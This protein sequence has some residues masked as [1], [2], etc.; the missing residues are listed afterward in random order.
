MITFMRLRRLPAL[1]SRSATPCL[2]VLLAA[3]GLY[4]GEADAQEL[5]PRAYWPA[6]KGTNLLVTAYQHSFGDVVT[7]ATLPLEGVDSTINF[8]QVTWQHTTSIFGRSANFQAN[9]PYAWGTTKGLVEGVFRQR[10][11]SNFADAR[12]L[13]SINLRGA[14]SMNLAE[15]R[16]LTA[17]PRTIVGASLLVQAPTGSY[18]K[19]RFINAGTNRWAAKLGFGVIWPL[20]R[21]WLLETHFGGWFFGDNDEFIGRKREQDPIASA[22]MHLIRRTDAE[23]WVALD[24]NYYV[25]G[26]TTVDGVRRDDR[27]RNSRAGVT[28]VVPFRRRHAI[29]ASF[30]TGIRT[31]SG[32]DFETLSLAYAYFW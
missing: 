21:K 20:Q 9:L 18:E 2:L 6:P 14:P 8:A 10:D 19:D 17:N 15:F 4:A 13:L 30:S 25:G 11:I 27:V 7:D 22:E 12:L 5:V 28:M 29:R 26:R 16:K 24:W 23:F 31:E 3:F 1:S 32:G